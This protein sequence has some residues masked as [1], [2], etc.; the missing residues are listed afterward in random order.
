MLSAAHLGCFCRWVLAYGQ[1]ARP[2]SVFA[3]DHESKLHLL[4]QNLLRSLVPD[5]FPARLGLLPSAGE[6]QRRFII[7][8]ETV[9]AIFGPSIEKVIACPV[10]ALVCI[11]EVQVY[12]CSVEVQVY[13]CCTQ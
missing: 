12:A 13:T 9:C 6:S 3:R 8:D 4:G 7:V 1:Q 11:G 5:S 10:H 2:I